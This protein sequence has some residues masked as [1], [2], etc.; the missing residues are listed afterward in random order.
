MSS[1]AAMPCHKKKP[2]EYGAAVESNLPTGFATKPSK[3]PHTTAGCSSNGTA[4]AVIGRT[5]GLIAYAPFS[6]NHNV[7]LANQ[8]QRRLTMARRSHAF[9]SSG[10]VEL[11]SQSGIIGAQNAGWP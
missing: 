2:M 7:S 1:E 10:A 3:C 5:Y 4:S 6:E 9:V 8:T 11:A